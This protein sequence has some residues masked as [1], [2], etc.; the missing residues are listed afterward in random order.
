MMKPYMRI[1]DAGKFVIRYNR[2][3]LNNYNHNTYW[4]YKKF[5]QLL[6]VDAWHQIRSKTAINKDE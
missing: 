6:L 3:L 1:D 2:I 5:Q 4:F